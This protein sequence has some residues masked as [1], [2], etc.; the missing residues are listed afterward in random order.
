MMNCKDWLLAW[1]F[2]NVLAYA[3]S[4][5]N[6][7]RFVDLGS[8]AGEGADGEIEEYHRAISPVFSRK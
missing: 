6:E 8:R 7:A 1:R 4:D 3:S 5:I 2:R